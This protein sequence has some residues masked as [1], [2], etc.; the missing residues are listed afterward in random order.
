MQPMSV[1]QALQSLGLSL[2]S[3]LRDPILLLVPRIDHEAALKDAEV[4]AAQ[5]IPPLTQTALRDLGRRLEDGKSV[6]SSIDRM[7]IKKIAIRGLAER[8]RNNLHTIRRSTFTHSLIKVV[9]GTQMSGWED[10]VVVA[11]PKM[12]IA[13]PAGIPSAVPTLDWPPETPR[14]IRL[15]SVSF[16][17]AATKVV[18]G[19]LYRISI[20]GSAPSKN[21]VT[22]RSIRA[23]PAELI[24]ALSIVARYTLDRNGGYCILR[25]NPP[26]TSALIQV[27][28]QIR[29]QAHYFAVWQTAR[30][31][32]T[33]PTRLKRQLEDG[34]AIPTVDFPAASYR[35]IYSA[36]RAKASAEAIADSVI[37]REPTLGQGPIN[38]PAFSGQ[39]PMLHVEGTTVSLNDLKDYVVPIPPKEKPVPAPK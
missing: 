7:L 30:F 2:L 24:S 37:G 27:R 36:L 26:G 20:E 34:K 15:S 8:C 19:T 32:E 12:H 21:S 38:L 25:P 6:S 13:W 4:E 17:E 14:A 9:S 33:L 35:L 28:D 5:E 29:T 22:V 39:A 31:L 10:V 18:E 3:G 23:T 1:E 16:R 11:A